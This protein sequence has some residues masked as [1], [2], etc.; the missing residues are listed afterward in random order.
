M[1]GK[2]LGDRYEIIEKVGIGGMAVVYK[3]KCR[4]LNRYV[5]IKVLRPEFTEMRTWYES[6]NGNPRLQP[7]FPIRILSTSMM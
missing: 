3:A 5:G 7:V 1:I 6:L 4:L 2:I